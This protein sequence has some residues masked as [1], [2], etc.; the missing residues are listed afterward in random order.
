MLVGV[1]VLVGV[2][3]GVGVVEGEVVALL[4][5][6]AGDLVVLAGVILPFPVVEELEPLLLLVVLSIPVS[7]LPV[8]IPVL[9]LPVLLVGMLLLPESVVGVST[10]PTE[11]PLPSV[12][13]SLRATSTLYHL[14]EL[15]HEWV[16][17]ASASTISLPVTESSGH[18]PLEY[19]RIDA[20]P[21]A[22]SLAIF[23]LAC[24]RSSVPTHLSDAG[25]PKPEEN[26][27]QSALS[28]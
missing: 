8:P 11:S 15:T 19:H 3:L 10:V 24:G 26:P 2:G 13:P 12:E 17:R 6:V 7:L 16:L 23:A 27:V 20:D 22:L 14:R 25:I 18:E 4:P 9:L 5:D 1:G 21:S 28:N